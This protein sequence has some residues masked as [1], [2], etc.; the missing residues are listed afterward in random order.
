MIA[1]EFV[2]FD[3]ERFVTVGEDI[4]DFGVLVAMLIIESVDTSLPI[5]FTGEKPCQAGDV[6]SVCGNGKYKKSRVIHVLR[7]F[8]R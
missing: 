2:S 5:T 8:R 7:K 4:G 1:L 6:I 3:N